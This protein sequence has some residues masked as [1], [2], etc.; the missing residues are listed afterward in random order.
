M[1]KKLLCLLVFVSSSVYAE[2]PKYQWQRVPIP[3]LDYYDFAGE[4]VVLGTGVRTS[5]EDLR[6]ECDEKGY[7]NSCWRLQ[8][9]PKIT[10]DD[11]LCDNLVIELNRYEYPDDIDD[12]KAC[13]IKLV[14]NYPEFKDPDWKE[15]DPKQ[16]KNL[17]FQIK[18][19]GFLGKDYFSETQG[20]ITEDRRKV[21][22]KISWDSV[23]RFIDQG[24]QL[25]YWE[26]PDPDTY[27]NFFY[28][29]KRFPSHHLLTYRYPRKIGNTYDQKCIGMP[30]EKW[31][32]NRNIT[33]VITKNLTGPAPN[34]AKRHDYND[35]FYYKNNLYH[36]SGNGYADIEI[37]NF[38]LAMPAITVQG[39]FCGISYL[40]IQSTTE[41]Q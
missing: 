7:G 23:N 5:E 16:Y 35:Y 26:I 19:S 28:D 40:P 25:F 20:T 8:D 11:Q 22:E 37:G 36:S 27:M 12:A 32:K 9:Y 17:M 3:D 10:E 24:G 34:I 6:R 31:H 18:L 38:D 41:E 21:I 29:N 30:I 1:Y 14:D 2:T 13:G 39:I 4:P 33:R 15:L